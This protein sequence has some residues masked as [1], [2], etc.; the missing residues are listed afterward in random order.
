MILLLFCPSLAKASVTK[1]GTGSYY[2][3]VAVNTAGLWYFRWIGTGAAQ[4]A[5][6]RAFFVRNSEIV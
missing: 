3:N 6:E 5:E 2:K 4:A 1:D